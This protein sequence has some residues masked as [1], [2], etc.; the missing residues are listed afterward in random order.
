MS[1]YYVNKVL[2]RV[3]ND[4]AFLDA[5][6]ADP[7]AALAAFD[8]T[9]AERTALR[10]GDVGTLFLMGVHPFLLNG[11]ARH[12]VLGVSRDNYLP[13]VRAAVAAAGKED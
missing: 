5:V 4:R 12:Q 10:T 11:L 13:R 1:L 7:D 2:F 8:L 9:E 3:E 6:R